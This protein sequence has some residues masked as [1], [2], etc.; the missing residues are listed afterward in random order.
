MINKTK[1]IVLCFL[2]LTLPLTSLQGV[3]VVDFEDLS[4]EK[5]RIVALNTKTQQL[6]LYKEAS[7]ILEE[8]LNGYILNLTSPGNAS[9]KKNVLPFLSDPM[10][11]RS[12]SFISGCEGWYNRSFTPYN[13]YSSELITIKS[14]QEIEAILP[15]FKKKEDVGADFSITREGRKGVQT[16]GTLSNA[17]KGSLGELATTLTM[18]S[19]GYSQHPAKYGGDNGLD[20]V[21]ESW[22]KEYIWLTQTKQEKKQRTAGNIM[23]KFLNEG[24]I[25]ETIQDM[26]RIG[27][28]EV[29]QTAV[30][31]RQ[32]FQE[33]PQSV[34]KLSY[35]MMDKGIA[36]CQVKPLNIKEF[37]RKGPKLYKAPLKDKIQSV[38][39]VLGGF[40]ENPDNQLMLVLNA[41][42]LTSMSKEQALSLLT[43]AFD[44]QA[45]QQILPA[46]NNTQ[47]NRQESEDRIVQAIHPQTIPVKVEVTNT[48]ILQNRQPAANNPK[49]CYSRD[50]LFNFLGYLYSKKHNERN[51]ASKLKGTENASASSIGRLM[52][53]KDYAAKKSYQPIWNALVE[54]YSQEYQDWLSE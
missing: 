34:Y 10:I 52:K 31:I 18:L 5:T 7:Q 11:I 17:S 36:Q 33:K 41:I 35:R 54:K 45:T 3:I 29:K 46:I 40:E 19:F 53:D 37:P 14:P 13:V 27:R 24:K 16:L 23:E 51:I 15:K 26:E 44:A 48:E 1:S 39:S 42:P 30:L 20:G 38:Q 12:K 47:D 6:L 21:F 49:K 50:N 25:W 22:S 32:Y 43:Q 9:I 2:I 28:P 4:D 8:H